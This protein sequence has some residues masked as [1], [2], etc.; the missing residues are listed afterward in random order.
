MY[1]GTLIFTTHQI[2]N[3]NTLQQICGKKNLLNPAEIYQ[4]SLHTEKS[5]WNLIKLIQ[6]QIV[7]TI[8]RLIW[9]QKDVRFVPNQS[10]NAKYNLI[11]VLFNKIS[12]RFLCV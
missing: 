10:E 6:N 12:R 5:F 4:P 9:N 8:F 7:Y 11:L 1:I 3:L 2:N